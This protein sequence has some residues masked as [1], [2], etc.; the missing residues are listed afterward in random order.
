MTFI[1][2]CLYYV[3]LY[4]TVIQLSISYTCSLVANRWVRIQSHINI[5]LKHLLISHILLFYLKILQFA[6]KFS[7][8]RD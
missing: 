4:I 5:T 6:S 3:V 8:Q 7:F 1:T 2:M